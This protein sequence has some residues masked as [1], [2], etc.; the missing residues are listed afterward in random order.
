MRI[1]DAGGVDGRGHPF[2]ELLGGF[3]S[4][5]IVIE[6]LTLVTLLAAGVHVHRATCLTKFER[7]AGG[8]ASPI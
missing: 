2:G 8:G 7:V 4:Q 6:R 1:R 3:G 5:Q